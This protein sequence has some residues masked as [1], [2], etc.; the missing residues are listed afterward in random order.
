MLIVSETV[1]KNMELEFLHKSAT[2]TVDS[3]PSPPKRE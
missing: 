3:P 1:K 2:Y